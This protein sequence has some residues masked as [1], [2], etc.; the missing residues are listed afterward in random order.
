M[1]ALIFKP[2]WIPRFF[3]APASFSLCRTTEIALGR[4]ALARGALV[5]SC[6]SVFAVCFLVQP[7][8]ITVKS[9]NAELFKES[10]VIASLES[11]KDRCFLP[12]PRWPRWRFVV[13]LESG[14]STSQSLSLLSTNLMRFVGIGEGVDSFDITGTDSVRESG[15]EKSGTDFADSQFADSAL[16]D[17]ASDA[18]GSE[19]D[20]VK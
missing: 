13:L 7:P 3:F 18:R 1:C 4:A 10:V 2:L 12:F 19:V 9:L 6:L 14:F 17:V 5:R 20:L 15:V 11:K 8:S 16:A